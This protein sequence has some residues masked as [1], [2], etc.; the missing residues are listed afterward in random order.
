M[1]PHELAHWGIALDATQQIVFFVGQHDIPPWS[2]TFG[3]RLVRTRTT[4]GATGL[5]LDI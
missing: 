4:L 1:A 5:L 2:R 3:A